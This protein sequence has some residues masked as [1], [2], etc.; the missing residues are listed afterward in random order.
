MMQEIL[1][2]CFY[3]PKGLT[4]L[5]QKTLVKLYLKHRTEMYQPELRYGNK[6][7]LKMFCF[8]HHWSAKD[9]KYH[10]IRKDFDQEPVA[11]MPLMLKEMATPFLNQAFSQIENQLDVGILNYYGPVG[12]KL[13]LHQDDSEKDLSYPIVSF[14]IGASCIFQIGGLQRNDS[15]IDLQLNSGD[16]LIMGSESRLRFHGVKRI[17]LDITKYRDPFDLW[18]GSGRINFTLRKL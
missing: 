3:F 8:G 15:T 2:D 10:N 5:Q 4:L 16:V 12:S 9:Y 1:P 17:V 13:G 18:L 6:M 14:S 11:E 7:S